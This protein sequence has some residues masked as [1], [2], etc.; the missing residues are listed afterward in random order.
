MSQ[1]N[2]LIAMRLTNGD[3]QNVIRRLLPES[4]GSFGD[5][6]PILDTGEALVLGDA[7]LLP[8]RIRIA[9]PD[10]PPNSATVPFWQRWSESDGKMS[11]PS[12][13]ENWRKQ[14][15]R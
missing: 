10:N 12:A 4:L 11:V 6:L 15:I 13:V 7:T 1:C 9:K 14:A 8:T 5:L 2:N 3:D